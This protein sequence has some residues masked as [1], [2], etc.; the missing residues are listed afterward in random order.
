[1]KII[2]V[3]LLANFV[4][5]P[6]FAQHSAKESF[7]VAMAAGDSL[8]ENYEAPLQVLRGIPVD[9][10]D[11]FGK[12]MWLQAMMTYHSFAG[13]YDSTLYYA[14]AR[15]GV[16]LDT[17]SIRMDTSFMLTYQAV[18][19]A[20]YLTRL[21]SRHQVTML[22]EAHHIPS[23][24]AFLIGLLKGFKDAGY[25]YLAIETLQ[26][27]LINQSRNVGYHTGYYS[28]EPL[29]A[30]AIRYALK[31][32]YQLVPYES[33]I[34]CDNAKSDRNYCNSFR[35]SVMAVNLSKVMIDDPTA[36]MLVFA[37]YD[38]IHKGN[39][40]GWKK[41]AEYFQDITG[42]EP[43]S[44]DQAIHSEHYYPQFDTKEFS[45]V[46]QS[47]NILRPVVAVKGADIWHGRFVDV[48]VIHPHYR[49]D[50]TRRPFFYEL[51]GLR[52]SFDLSSLAL[53]E[54]RIV[55]AYY[56]NEAPGKRIPADQIGGAE[57]NRVLYLFPGRYELVIK[58]PD[59]KLLDRRSVKVE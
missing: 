53:G 43:L 58:S 20:E 51:N 14:D 21:A 31:M 52:K 18:D 28:R 5:N 34:E 40:N 54:G 55:Q 32:G 29:F 30:E 59:G 4:V 36:K 2:I 35:D 33:Q 19:A 23:H 17:L 50:R 24:R 39:A 47:L 6:L 49:K 56:E 27:S 22:N 13:N 41:M 9:H 1:M 7:S 42:I 26:D 37:G 38:H 12:S 25:R 48:S 3:F 8:P 16:N 57:V 15:Y 10:Q 44:V 46:N 11:P 45:A